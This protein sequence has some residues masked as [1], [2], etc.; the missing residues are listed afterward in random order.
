MTGE[1]GDS[2]KFYG[3]NNKLLSPTNSSPNGGP[4]KRNRNNTDNQLLDGNGMNA[5]I[6]TDSDSDMERQLRRRE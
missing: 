2:L 1:D 3:G 4:R 5:G 6:N